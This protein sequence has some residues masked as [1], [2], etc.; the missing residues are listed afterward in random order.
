MEIEL[1]VLGGDSDMRIGYS[2]GTVVAIDGDFIDGDFILGHAARALRSAD[3]G[4]LPVIINS[5]DYAMVRVLPDIKPAI[6][7]ASVLSG[8]QL[9]H[10]ASR[11]LITI[12][13][14]G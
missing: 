10:V 2:R 14:Q 13:G 5:L 12:E 7:G 6:S 8:R 1:I 3:G 11:S 4:D 9:G